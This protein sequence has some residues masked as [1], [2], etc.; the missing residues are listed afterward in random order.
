MENPIDVAKQLIIDFY[1][2]EYGHA[3]AKEELDAEEDIPL[4][5][6]ELGDYNEYPVQ[7]YVNLKK[8]TVE[9]EITDENGTHQIPGLEERYPSL[10]ILIDSFLEYLNF[11][12]LI[13]PFYDYIPE[14]EE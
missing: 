2:R 10:Q 8:L 13:L 9:Y 7:V 1:E 5:Y 12:D 11:D 6:T 3:E 14:E 4:A